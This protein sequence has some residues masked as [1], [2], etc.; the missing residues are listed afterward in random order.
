MA[1]DLYKNPKTRKILLNL[2][3]IKKKKKIE[4][5]SSFD[6]LVNYQKKHIEIFPLRV[7]KKFD[8]S[9]YQKFADRERLKQ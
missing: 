8:K 6:N 1:I 3:K 5:S 2:D 9:F 7:L 4:R